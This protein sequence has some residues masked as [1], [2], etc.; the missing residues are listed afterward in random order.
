[1]N[2]YRDQ[3]QVDAC[4]WVLKTFGSEVAWDP[5]E[6]ARRFIEEAIELAQACGLTEFD[7]DDIL[8]HV[9]CKPPGEVFQ[10]AGGVGITLLMLCQAFGISADHAERTE[11]QRVQSIPAQ[12]FRDRHNIK[13]AAGV[14]EKVT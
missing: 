13:A 4:T 1:M 5:R 14:A 9:Y 10:E 6:R 8:A 3:R 11:L 2:D 12:H 7:V